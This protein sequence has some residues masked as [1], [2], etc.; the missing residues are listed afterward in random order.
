MRPLVLKELREHRW[1]LLAL[2]FSSAIGLVGL[3]YSAK[4]EARIGPAYWLIFG[5]DA[6]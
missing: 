2:W 1:V 5:V 4:D 3:L 6:G